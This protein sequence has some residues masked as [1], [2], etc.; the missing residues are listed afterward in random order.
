MTSALLVEVVYVGSKSYKEDNI[1]KTGA[2]WF[3]YGDSQKI[4]R[5]YIPILL[6]HPDVWMLKTEFDNRGLTAKTSVDRSDAPPKPIPKMSADI[7][8]RKAEKVK[9]PQ[10]NGETA[11][12][13][14]E[15]QSSGAKPVAETGLINSTTVP[16]ATLEEIKGALVLMLGEKEKE[17]YFNDKGRPRVDSVRAI[18]GK[19]VDIKLLN[20]AWNLVGGEG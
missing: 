11:P 15:A 10:P 14:Q 4:E 7:A 17:G 2:V 8:P 12:A 20:E 1:C 13:T 5:K 3:G 9:P 16:T 19:D 18:C 6:K